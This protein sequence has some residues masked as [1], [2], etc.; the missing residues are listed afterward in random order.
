MSKVTTCLWFA[1]EA[2]EAAKLYTSLV[3][4]SAIEGVHGAPADNPGTAEGAVLTVSF[5]LDG[6]RFMGLNGGRPEAYGNAASIMVACDTQGEI[7]RLWD[8]LLQGG[9]KTLACGW[10]NDRWGVPW[11]IYPRRLLELTQGEDKAAAQRVFTAMM[12][13]VKL[14]LAGLEDAARA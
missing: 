13:M 4:N 9:G 2:H 1:S 8:A 5:I 10:L 12:G 14:D 3:P 6:Q 11:Q 7:D